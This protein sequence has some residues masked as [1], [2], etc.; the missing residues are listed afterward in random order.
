MAYSPV[1]QFLAGFAELVVVL[2]LVFRRTAWIG[3]LLGTV[4]LGTVF[5]LNMT[6]DVPVK[7]I[8]LALTV[9]VRARRGPGVAAGGAVPGRAPDGRDRG[10]PAAAA[11]A[12]GPPGHPVARP[13]A[14]AGPGRRA[15]RAVPAVPAR[16]PAG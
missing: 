11:V 13:G 9:G 1:I 16:P 5:L 6:Y 2:L 15:G 3:G 7:Q 14:R 10:G 4:A 8:A 12:E